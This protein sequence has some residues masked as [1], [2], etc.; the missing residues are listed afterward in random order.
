MGGLEFTEKLLGHVV[1]LLVGYAWPAVAIVLFLT[2]KKAISK[3]I[4]RIKKVSVSA[5]DGVQV[6]A[7]DRQLKESKAK[8]EAAEEAEKP[9]L[10]QLTHDVPS[11]DVQALVQ[12]A[13]ALHEHLEA[14]AAGDQVFH[15]KPDVVIIRMWKLIEDQLYRLVTQEEPPAFHY[16]Q[17]SE[18]M[19][20]VSKANVL[21][22]KLL[23]AI[24]SLS[25]IYNETITGI[26]GWA[27]T[28]EQA[29]EFMK[30]ATEVLKLLEP[31]MQVAYK[32]WRP[33][34]SEKTF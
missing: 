17:G 9:V 20:R 27:P 8:I 34:V 1:T 11:T 5:K 26:M 12:S 4:K 21:D 16:L 6:E 19:L 23:D 30:N 10:E 33:H 25:M 14:W 3:V 2:Q 15:T 31:Y 32:G 22:R 28:K 29:D 7:L 24:A 18:L 13:R